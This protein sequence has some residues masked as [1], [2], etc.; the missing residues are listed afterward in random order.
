VAAAYYLP[1]RWPVYLP[2]QQVA[3]TLSDP[4]YDLVPGLSGFT[5]GGGNFDLFNLLAGR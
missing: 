3:E 1:G 2:L 5:T 4:F